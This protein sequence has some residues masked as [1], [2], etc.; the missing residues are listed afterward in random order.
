MTETEVLFQ[1]SNIVNGRLS[2]SYAVEQ[3]A[4]LLEREAEGKALLIDQL[5][6][7]PVKLL[8]SLSQPYRA[9]YTVDL[10]DGG[11]T[12]GKATL[13]FASDE[14]L[15]TV[16]QRLAGF[17]GEQ[18]GM[19]LARTRLAEKRAKLK[20]EIEKIG[21]DLARRKV[22]QRAEGILI[23]KRGMTPAAAKAW[24]AQQSRNTGLST[25]DI[26]ERLI[27]YYRTAGVLELRIA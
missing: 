27:A 22:L 6:G 8:D 12:L 1:I 15:G 25:T 23:A 13:C 4:L 24:I 20:S 5:N 18:L 2:F 19:L 21:Q 14:L 26:A 10:R 17:V 11:E 16:P 7:D 9:L 3:I